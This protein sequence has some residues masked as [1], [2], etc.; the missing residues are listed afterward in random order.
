MAPPQGVKESGTGRYTGPPEQLARMK[1]VRDVLDALNTVGIDLVSYGITI[2]KVYS[3]ANYAQPFGFDFKCAQ[4]RSLLAAI[5]AKSR[6]KLAMRFDDYTTDKSQPIF[7]EDDGRTL[8]GKI[9]GGVTKGRGFRQ[10]GTG[11]AL[12]IEIDAANDE[13]NVHIDSH[14]YVTA[15]GTY[16]WTQG[17]LHGYWDLGSYYL[18]SLYGTLGGRGRVGLMTRPIKG[19]RGETRWIFGFW[20][21]F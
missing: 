5:E 17:L 15:P 13:C 20:G 4:S 6:R 8:E 7:N 3:R 12:H 16:D 14:G 19:P 18:P 1:D 2:T 11:A 21:E 9:S 10:I